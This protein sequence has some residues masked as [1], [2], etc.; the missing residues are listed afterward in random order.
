MMKATAPTDRNAFFRFELSEQCEG[1]QCE[2]EQ[3][4]GEQ[5][6]GEQCE[7]EHCE[8]EQCAGEQCEG[9]DCVTGAGH[10][11]LHYKQISKGSL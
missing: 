9:V 3:Y 8:G 1:D 10:C 4:E 5:C 11:K 7:V 6:E 2:G